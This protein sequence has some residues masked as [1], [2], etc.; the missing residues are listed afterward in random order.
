MN[1]IRVFLWN[2]FIAIR[3]VK[4]NQYNCMFTQCYFVFYPVLTG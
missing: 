3:S 2:F 4:F 1:F